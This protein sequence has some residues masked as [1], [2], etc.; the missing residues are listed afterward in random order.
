MTIDLLFDLFVISLQ[1]IFGLFVTF[2]IVPDLFRGN[3]ST[4][5]TEGIPE[6]NVEPY[7]SLIYKPYT[8]DSGVNM[9]ISMMEQNS[10]NARRSSN[11]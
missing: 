2:I 5:T 6:C 3:A 1:L 9:A 10:A 7:A 8:N 4:K 11:H